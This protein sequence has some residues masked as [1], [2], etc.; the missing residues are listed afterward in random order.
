MRTTR[1]PDRPIPHA[2]SHQ[3]TKERRTMASNAAAERF[4]NAPWL[5]G[6]DT[7]DRRALLNVLGEGRAGPDVVLLGEGQLNDRITFLTEGTVEIVRDYP[8][9]G[10]EIV[11][12]LHAPSVFG[13]TSF[14]RGSPSVVTVRATTPVSF[15]TL[16]RPAHEALRRDNPRAA[17]Q[18]SLTFVR[19]LADRFDV[20]DQRVSEFIARGCDDANG[21]PNPPR[22]DEWVA[23]RARLFEERKI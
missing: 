10:E 2:N 4:L 20:L 5:S 22:R 15:L 12:T 16:D 7:S 3:D 13:E 17:E 8:D 21:T 11:A 1:S 14:F 9:H 19:V 23:F 18:L 6:L